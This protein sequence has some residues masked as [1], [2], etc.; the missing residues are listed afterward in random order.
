MDINILSELD[1][2]QKK[3]EYIDEDQV[4]TLCPFHDDTKASCD[5]HLGKQKFICRVCSYNGDIF[6]YLAKVIGV[7]R[8]DILLDCYSRYGE[9]DD[10]SI[11]VAT[12]ERY[13]TRIWK[14][15]PLLKALRDRCITDDVIRRYRLGEDRGRI[16]IPISNS[17]GTYVNVRRYEPGSTG[18]KMLNNKGRGKIRLYPF[19]QLSYDKVF[20]T[21]GEIKALASTSVLNDAGIGC[22]CS[23]GGEGNWDHTHSGLFENKEVWVC[24][25]IDPAGV[26]A[27]DRLCAA[28]RTSAKIV[29]NVVLPLDPERFP[30]GDVN[31]FLAEGGNLLKLVKASKEWEPTPQVS[32]MLTDAED[33]SVDNVVVKSIVNKR[34]KLKTHILATDQD[35][36]LAPKSLKVEC[37]QDQPQCSVCPVIGRSDELFNIEP[38]SE[39]LLSIIDSNQKSYHDN[40][41][42]ALG[43]PKCKV[44]KFE[45]V[46]YFR[47][48]ETRISREVSLT[49]TSTDK[50]VMPAICVDY[51]PEPN[52]T[53]NMT[54]RAY[55]NP[56]TQRST[57]LSSSTK[58]TEDALS[59][60][61]LDDPG[62]LGL[63]QAPEWTIDGLED[64]LGR[65][66]RDFESNVTRVISR[67][68][69]HLAIDLVYHSP[70]LLNIDGLDIKGWTELLVIGD[71]SQGKSYTT[72][73]LKRHYGLGETL[74][75]KNATVAGVLGGLQQ[76]NG[77]WFASWGVIPTHDR[78][79]IILEELK[80]MPE[81][82]FV[83]L[84]DMRSSGI[85]EITKIQRRKTQART[86]L[87]ALSNPKDDRQ[88]EEYNF[89]VAAIKN[90]IHNPEDI[91]RF[92]LALVLDKRSIKPGDLS[93]PP[94]T[95]HIFTSDLCRKLI[96]WS[97]TIND[98]TFEDEEYLFKKAN[99]LCE[100][101]SEKIPLIDR[102]SVRF[103]L[104]R[105]AAALAARTF[106]CVG[107][108]TGLLVRNCHVDYIDKF[109]REEYDD[110]YNGYA[111]YSEAE[112]SKNSLE[113][114]DAIFSQLSSTPYPELLCKRLLDTH[115]IETQDFC[116]WCSYDRS[117][118]SLVISTL[119]RNNALLRKGR[120][121]VK[122]PQFIDALRQWLSGDS[123]PKR[124]SHLPQ[125]IQGDF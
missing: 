61:K 33:E 67:R 107:G 83:K 76:I 50:I 93:N 72:Q 97:W 51:G 115:K 45:P 82:V 94:K 92:D 6:T 80:G 53:Y 10:K 29:R 79:L 113:N 104:G 110:P 114:P 3:F 91:R 42:E 68:R 28:L 20:I 44:V 18:I 105:L 40:L 14:A 21:G 35:N 109:L 16:T 84:T 41:R 46:D 24:L 69:L 5:I 65:I 58:P 32:L 117:E 64:I 71:S 7:S 86:R 120:H 56:K 62:Q 38:E 47:L 90:L 88:L 124:P 31:D 123:L 118:S 13:H 43:I 17:A 55:P 70:L 66:Y 59:T 87:I 37:T 112:N 95:E 15:L 4:R 9:P 74:E 102:G 85:A 73:T 103:K 34:L 19:D 25:D 63:F 1:R 111:L 78:R 98:V 12:V 108:G 23:T 48:T 11:N 89:G 99:E 52:E 125:N 54:G 101:Y 81:G 122:T 26:K 119:V 77:R 39:C 36:Y 106:S 49:D 8:N 30:N 22:I 57:F 121:Y 96:L 60:F 116:D 100:R 75:C 2:V 27:A